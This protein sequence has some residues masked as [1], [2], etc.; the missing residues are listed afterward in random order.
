MII[1]DGKKHASLLREKIKNE[2][3]ALKG[4]KPL[5]ASIQ[6]GSDPDASSYI[7]NKEK[8]CQAVGILSSHLS[9]P[10]DTKEDV[11]LESIKKLNHDDTVDGILLQLPL[12][13]NFNSA[14]II[15]TIDPGKDVDGIHPNNLGKL[16]SGQ[17]GFIPATPLAVMHLLK[18]YNI[19][20]SGMNTMIIG[21]SAIVGK[22]LS[23][24]LLA[25]NCTVTLAHSKSLKL[26]NESSRTDLLVAAI[27][28]AKLIGKH[29]IKPGAIVI[30]VGI[31]FVNSKLCGDVNFEEV[32]PMTSYITPVPGGVGS[33]TNTMILK[34]TLQ[35]YH[36]H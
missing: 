14:R 8:A 24:L 7:S 12:P 21:R 13:E 27:G 33:L 32:A 11:L 2:V 9:L 5:L 36:L 29:Y 1:M 17:V 35:A 30:D 31:N 3:D 16:M 10:D 34:N 28:R 6:V 26:E 18:A 23:L 15:N 20:L 19:P 25:E 22:P 4:R